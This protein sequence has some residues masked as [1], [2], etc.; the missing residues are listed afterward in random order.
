[1]LSRLDAPC[2]ALPTHC[3]RLLVCVVV[4]NNIDV[5]LNTDLKVLSVVTMLSLS[6]A[7]SVTAPMLLRA[8][9]RRLRC[10]SFHCATK[11]SS[12]LITS[13]PAGSLKASSSTLMPKSNGSSNFKCSRK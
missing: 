13:Q 11:P 3:N 7:T 2:L 12:Y 5:S 10:A 1:M 6:A 4:L 9:R 8:P